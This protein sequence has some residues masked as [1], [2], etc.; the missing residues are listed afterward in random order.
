MTSTFDERMRY[1]GEQV[2]DG[3][4]VMGCGVDQIYAQN[5]HETESFKHTSG[6][7]HYLGAPLLEN[8]FVLMEKLARNTITEH[9]SNLTDAAKDV[10]QDMADFVRVN[11]PKDTGRLSES[12]APFVDSEGMRIWEKAPSAPR[13][14]GPA[15]RGWEKRPPR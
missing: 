15:P 2:G 4:L 7:S 8:A 10:A 3:K 13:R 6:R 11:A 9:G 5:Q 1:L 14:I 12:G